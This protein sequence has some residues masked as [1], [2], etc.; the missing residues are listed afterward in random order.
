MIRTYLLMT[1]ERNG[2]LYSL[3]CESI[4]EVL[5]LTGWYRIGAVSLVTIEHQVTLG[6]TTA[7]TVPSYQ[8]ANTKGRPYGN[9]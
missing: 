2:K 9:N 4:D 7:E 1:A 5:T 6:P 8:P 3:L